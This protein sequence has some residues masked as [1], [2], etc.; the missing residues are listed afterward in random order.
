M[1]LNDFNTILNDK[2]SPHKILI[3]CLN[4]SIFSLNK[5]NFKIFYNIDLNL[6]DIIFKSALAKE[7]MGSQTWQGEC[8]CACD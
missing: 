8:M 6:S 7:D 5:P 1:Y 4:F 2:S 3:I